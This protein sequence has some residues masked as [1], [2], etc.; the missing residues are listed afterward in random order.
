M[1]LFYLFKKELLEVFR[2]KEMVA[3]LFV[4][5][6]LQTILLGYVVRTDV[7]NIPVK[8][9]NVSSSPDAY[10]LINR[11]THSPL[12]QVTGI[13][14]RPL[15]YQ[16]IFKRGQTKA[17]IVF[18]DE[19]Q[20]EDQEEKKTGQ[21]RNRKVMGGKDPERKERN[22]A[23]ESAE[24]NQA[25]GSFSQETNF[26]ASPETGLPSFNFLASPLSI[27]VLMDGADANTAMIATGYFY[28]VI[29]RY[30][31]AMLDKED[32]K[33]PLQPRTLI[34]YNPSLNSIHYMGP[35][36]VALLLTLTTLILTAIALVR[37]KEQQTLD[38]LLISRLTPG[39]IFLGKTLPMAL[40]GLVE[41]ILG[42]IVVLVLFGIHLR[43]NLGLLFLAAIFFLFSILS[44]GFLISLVSQSQQQALFFA[45]FTMILFLMLSGLLTPVENIPLAFRWLAEINPLRYLVK[46]IREIFLKGNDLAYFWKDLV[47]MAAIGLV[48]F[49]L[50]LLNFR[51][52]V[53]K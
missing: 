9:V 12:F 46:I 28:G 30:M 44:I 48:S 32:F 24:A 2:Q 47:I 43:G 21:T 35:G 38:T 20:T 3:I 19:N 26:S 18:A 27:Q 16:E 7:Q 52:S 51:R 10:R 5:P 4:A 50:S 6:I 39:E 11:L 42:I 8:I 41:M 37:E 53:V 33:L 22:F 17:I 1:K 45:W 25:L 15:N 29:K 14:H 23:D 36:I 31:E 49:L 40:I 13:Y 34:R